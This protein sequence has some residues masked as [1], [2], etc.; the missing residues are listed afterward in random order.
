M[1]EIDKSLPNV[2]QTIEIP[3]PDEIAVEV[4]KE[5]QEPDTPI[6]I[7]PN[8]DGSVDIDFDPS[9]GSQEQGQDHFANLAELL[10]DEVLSPIG[11]ELYDNYVDY[12]SGRKDWESSYTNGLELLGFKYEEKSEPF[13]GA[14]GATH[15]VLAEAVTQF[16]AL[17]YKELLPSQGPVRTQII[18]T[19][20]P[21][22]EQ[23]SLRVKEFMN[24]QIMSEMKEYES[25]F[26]Q[27]LFYL[28]LTGSTF[29][30]VY[31]DE[32]MQRT[33]SKF[34]PA[35][36]L[37]VPYTATSLDD[38]ETIIHVVKMSENE[39]RKQQ[40]AG[41]YRD[42]ELT[43]GQDNET[44]AQRKE[45]ELDGMAKGRNQ[46]MFTLLECHVN[47][48]I[49]GFEDTDTQGQ[50]TGIK[51]PYIVTVEEAS[52]EV[53]SIRRNYEVGDA[54][55]SKIQYFVHFKFLPG[56]GF[57]GFG[58]I[59]MIGGLSR[60][61]TAALR[62]L[63]DAGTL[64]N[65]PAGFKMRGIKM[66][67]EA[68][69]IQPGEFRDVDAPGGNLRDAFMPLPFKEPSGTLLNLMGVVV[70]AGQ[71]F[72][73]IADLQVGEGN[74]QAAVGTTVA[75]LERGSRTMSA[76][77]KRLYASMKRE[78][79]LMA[80][81]F[82]LYL[83]PV[84]PYDVVG[85]QRQIKQT[86]FD[87]RIDILPV[88]DP[89]I[90]SQTQRISLAQ[91]EMQLAASNPAI[92]NQ[93]EVYRNMYEALGVKDI[94]LIL[95]KPQPPMPKDPA[96]EHIDALGGV[97]FQAFPGQDHQAH[98]TAHLNFMETNM[99]K[100]SPVIGAAIQKN[101]LEHISLM[102]QEQIEI[103]FRQELPQL[104][105]MQQMAQQNP[106]LQQQVRMLSEKIEARKA[107][108]IS[109]MMSDFAKEENK[110]T[111]RFDND[112]IAALRAR[113]IDLQARENERK[114]REGKER[115]DLDR[116]K[117]MM[118]DQNQDEK[119]EQNEKLSKLRADTSIQKTILSKTIP[120]TDKIPDQVSIIRGGEQ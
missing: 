14:S 110:I 40:V 23:Q 89:N 120:S 3:S 11:N 37:V 47:L 61:A 6:N 85:G 39:L 44:D 99:V 36:D 57:Y 49:E 25:E 24:Y 69:P 102:A 21:D 64:S 18:G 105:Q 20:T 109:E 97:P 52:R 12:K 66:R 45:R 32:M 50:A 34:V 63:L 26:D 72:A 54:T 86:D 114:E 67:D 113:E 71:R 73:S 10:P 31:Y 8:E 117:A 96:L 77:H 4:E 13:K 93:Y 90:F 70:Q 29:K 100:N 101:I 7:K 79:S 42:V 33:V 5:Q 95:K 108:L 104:A 65:L 76:I 48:D 51:L 16:Q 56:L 60:S 112:P 74:Q 119:L 116:M 15:P 83:P 53:L 81:V 111:S 118:N 115:L 59:H 38:A 103:E 91:T 92:H 43:P 82:K 1:A 98:I 75:L 41:F 84:Y 94:D 55:R 78:F 28:P 80:R 62:S 19:P 88:A 30:K 68:Q 2:K 17:A 9:V 27:M 46:P 22:K 35:D 87:D 58:L 107:V 106:Q